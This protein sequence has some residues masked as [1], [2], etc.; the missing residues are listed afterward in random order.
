MTVSFY[1]VADRTDTRALRRS[2]EALVRD[3]F[4][5]RNRTL[6]FSTNR[7]L[8]RNGLRGSSSR[9]SEE[10]HFP[11]ADFW[12]ASKSAIRRRVSSTL[13]QAETAIAIATFLHGKH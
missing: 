3:R 4:E 12:P 1:R 2:P 5:P 9:G 11:Q 6:S 13:T 10:S 8:S 7:E